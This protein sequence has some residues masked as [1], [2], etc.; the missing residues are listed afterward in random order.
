MS[1]DTILCILSSVLLVINSVMVYLLIKQNRETER[2]IEQAWD[3]NVQE[4]S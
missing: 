2:L 1:V 4:E 3:S